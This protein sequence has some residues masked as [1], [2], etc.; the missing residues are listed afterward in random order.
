MA[1]Q[2]FY[3]TK[4]LAEATG[5]SPCTAYRTCRQYPGFAVRLNGVYKVP[6]EHLRRVLQGEHPRDIAASVQSRG[7]FSAA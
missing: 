5:S 4:K 7:A 3:S 2:I 6:G 1:N